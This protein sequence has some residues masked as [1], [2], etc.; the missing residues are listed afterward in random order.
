MTG[1][2]FGCYCNRYY[3][4][5]YCYKSKEHIPLVDCLSYVCDECLRNKKYIFKTENAELIQ[6]IKDLNVFEKP[7]H[8]YGSYDQD[9]CNWFLGPL[10]KYKYEK[11]SANTFSLV[12][13][14]SGK[15]YDFHSKKYV[16]YK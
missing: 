8:P 1:C 5:S 4:N 12:I 14:E 7:M 13:I 9:G 3:S 6:R 16:D 11:I 15:T 10:A 2:L